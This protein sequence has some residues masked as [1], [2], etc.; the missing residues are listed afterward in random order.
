MLGNTLSKRPLSSQQIWWKLFLKKVGN[1][2]CTPVSIITQ[3][4][5]PEGSKFK[6]FV[7][8]FPE[9]QVLRSQYQSAVYTALYTSWVRTCSEAYV[10]L[11]DKLHSAQ[12]WGS[13]FDNLVQHITRQGARNRIFQLS[14][15]LL[16]CCGL[17]FIPIILMLDPY[18]PNLVQHSPLKCI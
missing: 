10:Q 7:E 1:S 2:M 15:L 17:I 6:S 4:W 12:L 8:T 9:L 5:W 11:R 13:V 16:K 14:Q 3:T 18:C